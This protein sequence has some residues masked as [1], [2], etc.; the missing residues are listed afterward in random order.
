MK[1]TPVMVHRSDFDTD[2]IIHARWDRLFEFESLTWDAEFLAMGYHH[3]HQPGEM[4]GYASGVVL[5]LSTIFTDIPKKFPIKDL[6]TLLQEKAQSCCMEEVEQRLT[7]MARRCSQLDCAGD[8]P[9]PTDEEKKT[10][11]LADNMIDHLSLIEATERACGETTLVD[12]LAWICVWE[13][14]RAIRQA[15]D[16]C[17]A[18][19]NTVVNF[20]TATWETCFKVCIKAVMEEWD[21][22]HPK[23]RWGPNATQETPEERLTRLE[24]KVHELEKVHPDLNALASKVDKSSAEM[25]R[26]RVLVGEKLPGLEDIRDQC[27]HAHA[28]GKEEVTG[29]RRL[30]DACATRLELNHVRDK[31]TSVLKELGWTIAWNEDGQPIW[32]GSRERHNGPVDSKIIGYS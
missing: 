2:Q 9:N 30:A 28:V 23:K 10:A 5:G 32:N 4:P 16:S 22:R 27:R 25:G 19:G 14:E 29:V 21:K 7:L 11:E 15:F 6:L 20:E 26:L 18:S 3:P 13:S 8:S 12:A 17:R 24:G 1:L 31:I